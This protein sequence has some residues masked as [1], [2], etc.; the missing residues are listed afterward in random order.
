M[1]WLSELYNR[2]FAIP[3]WKKWMAVFLL[4]AVGSSI[5]FYYR[6]LPLKKELKRK[7]KEISTLTLTVK[8]TELF[9]KRRSLI[10]KELEK[11]RQQIK[12]IE[13]KLPTGKEDVEQIVRSITYADSG[14]VIESI[15]RESIRKH[16]YYIEYPY[17][18]VL[19]G[20]YPNFIRWCEKLSQANR[21]INFGDMKIEALQPIKARTRK[22]LSKGVPKNATIRVE[23]KIKAFTLAE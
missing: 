1:K 3:R 21:I 23:L 12:Q 2:W 16:K 14:M 4:A 8:R 11:L 13:S 18:V 19:V 9:K 6:I 15:T 5:F 22:F 10:L 20:T 17:K 7:Q